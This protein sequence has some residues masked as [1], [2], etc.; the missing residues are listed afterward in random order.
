MDKTSYVYIMGN[1]RLT[2]YIGVTSNLAKRLWEH[3]S[4][5]GKGFVDTYHLTKLL[6]FETHPDIESAIA[7]EKQ[8][9][10]WHREWKINLIKQQNPDLQDLSNQFRS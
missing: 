6:Y 5:C 7:R 1:E 4:S 8:L 3:R 9:K 10:N 2:I